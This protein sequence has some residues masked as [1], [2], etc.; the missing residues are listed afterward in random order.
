[1][2]LVLLIYWQSTS[3]LVLLNWCA[4]ELLITFCKV[5]SSRLTTWSL[6]LQWS[7]LLPVVLTLM[8]NQD[9]D[10][11]LTEIANFCYTKW[12]LEA[13]LIAN[14]KRF[15]VSIH[16]LQNLFLFIH[17]ILMQNGKLCY[18]SGGGLTPLTKLDIDFHLMI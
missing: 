6:T 7:V 4:F 1:M 15:D 17:F 8:A 16:Y 11:T 14:A 9:G 13:F 3:N 10:S 12:A 18:A 2:L 5:N